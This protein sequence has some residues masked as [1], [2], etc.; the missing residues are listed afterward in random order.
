MTQVSRLPPCILLLGCPNVGKSSLFNAL[1][2]KGRALVDG[3]AGTT[4]DV[5]EA[6]MTESSFCLVDM[7]GI[8]KDFQHLRMPHTWP[9]YSQQV[10][11]RAAVLWFVVDGKK[12]M[13]PEDAHLLTACRR[14]GKPLWVLVN[15]CDGGK[16]TDAATGALADALQWGV[17]DV[18][19]VSAKDKSGFFE[20]H[21]GLQQI[22]PKEPLKT[23]LPETQTILRAEAEERSEES[24]ETAT[25]QDAALQSSVIHLALVG[26]P[27]VGKSTLLN[28][29]VKQDRVLTGDQAGLTRDAIGVPFHIAGKGAVLWDTAGVRKRAQL[30]DA[31]LRDAQEETLRAIRFASVVVVLMDALQAFEKQDLTLVQNVID[32][33]RALVIGLNKWDCVPDPAAFKKALRADIYRLLPA[34]KGA[35]WVPLSAK[36][37]KGLP[38]LMTAMITARNLWSKRISTASLNQALQGIVEKNPPP[39]QQGKR[40]KVRYGVQLKTRPP[41]FCLF[42]SALHVLPD[43]Y[44]RYVLGQLRLQFNLPGVPL[45]IVLRNTKNPYQKTTKPAAR[46]RYTTRKRET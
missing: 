20:L 31:V 27:N 30:K 42:G 7:P 17:T 32:E 16:E 46:S 21:A 2:H 37:K 15:K 23:S 25:K 45:R 19:P 43:A 33:G 12:G 41:L 6:P 22:C 10:L 18:L 38:A 24:T 8:E 40:P 9:I 36:H 13:T 3:V 1:T 14:W 34:V 39:M 44:T 29:L 28:A 26:R 11:A 5:L 35:L 4:R